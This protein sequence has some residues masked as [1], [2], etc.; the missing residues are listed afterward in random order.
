MDVG[1]SNVV[2]TTIQEYV[3]SLPLAQSESMR[4][5]GIPPFLA[6][7]KIRRRNARGATHYKDSRV[8]AKSNGALQCSSRA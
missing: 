3:G 2:S 6:S 5:F 8:T 4:T 7:A 1:N